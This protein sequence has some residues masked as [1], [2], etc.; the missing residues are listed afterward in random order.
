M[1]RYRKGK[2]PSCLAA[3]QSTPGAKWSSL[4]GTERSEI[5]S[6]L[7]RDQGGLCAYCQRRLPAE[8]HA[9]VTRGFKIEHWEARA[10]EQGDFQWR[11]LLGA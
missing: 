8:D 10:E 7:T 2:T 3:L 5:R 9:D 1:L 11:H 4:G 6:A